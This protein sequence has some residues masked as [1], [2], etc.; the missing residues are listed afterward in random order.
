MMEAKKLFYI[1]N[2]G[3]VGRA[4]ESKQG[5]YILSEPR[6]FGWTFFDVYERRDQAL[7]CHINVRLVTPSYAGKKDQAL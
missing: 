4:V 6:R 2:R 1:R 5:A 3:E 7:H